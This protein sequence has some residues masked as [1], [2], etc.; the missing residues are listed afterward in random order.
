MKIF[1]SLFFFL[2]TNF[3]YGQSSRES[4]IDCDIKAHNTV[5]EKFCKTVDIVQEYKCMANEYKKFVMNSCSTVSN[6]YAKSMYFIY[7]QLDL[8]IH[9]VST[10]KITSDEFTTNYKNLFEIMS[11]EKNNFLREYK[12]MMNQI[13]DARTQRIE[14]YRFE[15]N[16]NNAIKA[17]NGSFIKNKPNNLQSNFSYIING[18]VVNCVQSEK[19]I[20]C[21]Y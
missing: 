10:K 5:D 9:Q 8:N 15:S 2:I 19:L 17:L 6:N 1:F 18:T 11:V 16:I 4:L 7:T 21:N 14:Q 12:T 20:N 13:W 3:S